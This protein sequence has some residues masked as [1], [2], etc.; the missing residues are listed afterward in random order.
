MTSLLSSE[1]LDDFTSLTLIA[2]AH[3]PQPT[4]GFQMAFVQ[5]GNLLLARINQCLPIHDDLHNRQALVLPI[6]GSVTGLSRRVQGPKRLLP[7][8]A[9]NSTI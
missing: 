2:I 8:A 1:S 5:H 6:L 9:R 7:S 3:S 4:A